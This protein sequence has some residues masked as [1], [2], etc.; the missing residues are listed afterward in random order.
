L[1]ILNLLWKGALLAEKP[2]QLLREVALI[3][4]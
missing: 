2:T 4:N 3:F 1:F